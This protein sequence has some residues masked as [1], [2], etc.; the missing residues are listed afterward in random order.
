MHLVWKRAALLAMLAVSLV[1][2]RARANPEL[3]AMYDARSVGMGGTGTAFLEGA[4]GGVYFNPALLDGVDKLDLS[5]TAAPF[6]PQISAPIAQPGTVSPTSQTDTAGAV[7]PLFL[8]GVGVRV[9]ERITLGLGAY[10]QSGLGAEFRNVG[11][12]DAA[13]TPPGARDDFNDLKLQVAVFEATLPIAVRITDKLSIGAA[14]R[15]AYTTQSTTLVLPNAAAP[16]VVS[17]VDQDVSG[18]SL[19]GAS[20]GVTVRPIEALSLA[21]SYRTKMTMD[22]EGT[23]NIEANAAPPMAPTQVVS[24]ADTTSAWST[25]HQLRL[26][27]ALWLLDER[28]L[29]SLE[30]RVQFYREANKSL[31]SSVDLNNQPLSMVLMQ[32]E[33]KSSRQL[34]W[35]DAYSAQLGAEYWAMSMLALRAG[36][37]LGNSASSRRYVNAFTPSPGVLYSVT[38]GLGL[39]WTHWEAGLAGSYQHG[40]ADV[41]ASEIAADMNGPVAPAGRYEGDLV[42]IA[43]SVGYRM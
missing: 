2:G 7:I 36:F 24:D 16:G 21:L 12:L 34:G 41:K 30:G 40:A 9:H 14:W 8:L 35:K 10:V 11:I 28:L 19:L 31:D 42:V 1:S 15:T 4:T 43:L 33:L 23:T 13:A 27:S 37:T 22:L 20:F 38:A 18:F 29:L 32:S 17:R 26:G 39:K 6:I 3:P 5:V 25:P